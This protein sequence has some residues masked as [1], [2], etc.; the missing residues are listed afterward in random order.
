MEQVRKNRMDAGLQKM[1][2]A[3]F[4]QPTDAIFIFVASEISSP[5]TYEYVCNKA[6]QVSSNIYMPHTVA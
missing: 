2:L 1:L 6:E 4:Y 3:D 5:T